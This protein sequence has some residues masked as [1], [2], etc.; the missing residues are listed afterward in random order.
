MMGP[1]CKVKPLFRGEL[2]SYLIPEVQG[3]FR[4]SLAEQP[5]SVDR[6]E[7]DVGENGLRKLECKENLSCPYF[8]I[9]N[10]NWQPVGLSGRGSG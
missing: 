10:M 5:N 8:R 1:G 6:T 7:L 9:P 4:I 2:L 3:G